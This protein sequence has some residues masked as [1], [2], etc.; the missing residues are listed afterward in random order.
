MIIIGT[1]FF[2]W[3]SQVAPYASQCARC[4]TMANFI[5]KKGMNVITIFFVIPIIPISGVSNL[6]ECPNC[7]T[8]YNA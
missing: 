8:R 7:H 6:L 4:G 1:K 5:L 3:G 2:V